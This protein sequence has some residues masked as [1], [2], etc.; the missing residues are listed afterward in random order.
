MSS[1]SVGELKMYL[2]SYPDDYEVI[3]N[4]HHKYD[5]SKESGIA[6]WLAMING[7]HVDDDKREVRLMN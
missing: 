7:I 5:I 1:I 4:I 6:G 3:M 2:D